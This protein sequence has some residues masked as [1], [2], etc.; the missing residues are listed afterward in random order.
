MTMQFDTEEKE[1]KCKETLK[2]IFNFFSFISIEKT[3]RKKNKRPE[4]FAHTHT[5]KTIGLRE[6]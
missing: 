6:K 2:G 3:W 5:L 4:T 1:K